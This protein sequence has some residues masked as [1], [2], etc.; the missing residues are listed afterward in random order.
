MPETDSGSRSSPSVERLMAALPTYPQ[1]KPLEIID[2]Q[3]IQACTHHLPCSSDHNFTSL[4]MWDTDERTRVARVGKNLVIELADYQ[5]HE[6]CLTLIGDDDVA[7]TAHAVLSSGKARLRLVPDF[8]ACHLP[9]ET[10][11]VEPERHQDDYVYN[12]PHLASLSGAALSK[13]RQQARRCERE[14]GPRLRVDSELAEPQT[15]LLELFDRWTASRGKDEAAARDERAAVGR[16]VEAW[17]ELE[18]LTHGVYDGHNLIAAHVD[19]LLPDCAIAHYLKADASY[20]GIFPLAKRLNSQRLASLGVSE[21]N[22]E[23][24]LGIEG[25]RSSKLRYKPVRFVKKY[26]VRLQAVA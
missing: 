12:V 24:D 21:H 14:L 16:L 9:P 5:T 3:A 23:Q 15:A 8:V 7:N 4:W 26:E 13:L 2:R 18:L 20:F 1:M 22:C 17:D 10:F 6:P 19:E 25:L 11:R